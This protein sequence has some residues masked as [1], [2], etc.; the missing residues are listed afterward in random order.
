MIAIDDRKTGSRLFHQAF[1]DFAKV[2]IF[3]AHGSECTRFPD[4]IIRHQATDLDSSLGIDAKNSTINLSNSLFGREYEST[5][6]GKVV[7]YSLSRESVAAL[8]RVLA[9]GYSMFEGAAK[10]TRDMH[11]EQM[12]KPR[13]EIGD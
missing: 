2:R 4:Q 8:S 11:A 9:C 6:N 7:R 10:R 1:P 12:R 5:F 13:Q 3:A